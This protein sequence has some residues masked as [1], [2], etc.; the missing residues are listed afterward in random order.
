M[1]RGYM[2]KFLFVDLSTGKITE[3]Y[4]DESL[5]RDFIGGYGIGARILYNRQKSGVDPLGPDNTLG[6]ITGP[7]TGTPATFGCRWVAVGKSPL[8]GGWGDANCGGYF[9]PYLKFAGYDGVFITGIS[10]KP[11]Y[12]LID[13]GKAEIKDASHLWG[14]ITHEVE[15]ALETEYGPKSRAIAIGPAG[16]NMS[17]ISCIMHNRGDAAGR[18]GMGAVMG[19][20]KLKAVVVRGDMQ[21]PIAA[22]DGANQLRKEHIEEGKG[23]FPNF[24]VYGTAGH[25]ME[26]AHSGDS[27]V[28]NWGGIGVI[29]L[30]DNS[31]LDKEIIKAYVDK[32]GG[33]W[34]CPSACKATMKAGP[35]EY[36]YPVG[37]HRPEYETTAAFG[38]MCLNAEGH[39]VVLANHLC[40]IYGLDTISTGTTLAFAM[41]CYEHG[42]ITKADT[43][44]IEM[45]WGNQKA[46]ITMIEKMA[47]REGFGDILAD[48]VNKAALKIG[49]DAEKYAVHIGGQELGL[50]DPKSGFIAFQGKPMMA[51]YHMDATPGRHTTGFGPTQFT[52]YVIG[53]AGVCM[54]SNIG[55][56]DP[57]KYLVGFLRT[58]TGW[59][60]S[61]EELCKDG[62]RIGNM[63]HLFSLREGDVPIKRFVHPRIPGRPPFEDG[64]VAGVSMDVEQQAYWNLGAL[65]WDPVTNI[66]SKKKL[67]ELGLND[68]TEELW[69]EPEGPSGIMPIE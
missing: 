65:D 69:P 50:H 49:G 20:K 45:T 7:L 30:P 68:I 33:C 12:L 66:P 61:L 46:M 13:N 40:N 39:A 15:E 38:S 32:R 5:Y 17:L 16:E 41:E 55:L 26:S 10:E 9:G 3:E 34:H 57:M 27:P 60:R 6:L 47:R 31:G 63:R 2:G 36:K 35:E 52:G 64:P 54:H 29:D 18:S 43:D 8:S 58:V 14:K 59:D 51:M 19:S 4:P 37:A 21:V 23:W 53:A 25:A 11:V 24:G 28:K 42:V 56:P 22:P 67:I 48:G 1:T 62:E 44:G